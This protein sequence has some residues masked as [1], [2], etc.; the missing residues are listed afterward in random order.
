MQRYPEIG[1]FMS[2]RENPRRDRGA[3]AALQQRN[4]GARSRAVRVWIR[5]TQ[6][7]SGPS[8]GPWM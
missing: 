1:G 3:D 2:Q 6:R 7:P 8:I 5:L 4:P